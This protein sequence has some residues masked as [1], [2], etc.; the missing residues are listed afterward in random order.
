LDLSGQQVAQELAILR[1]FKMLT[2]AP[3]LANSPKTTEAYTELIGIG[4][5]PMQL[6]LS[7]PP[8]WES[9]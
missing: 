5:E 7:L 8:G 4:P 9:N 6:H 3:K 1:R 2:K